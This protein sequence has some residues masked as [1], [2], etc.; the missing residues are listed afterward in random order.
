MRRQVLGRDAA[1]EMLVEP[2]RP[3]VSL[4]NPKAQGAGAARL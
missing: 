2:L 4:Q 3:R 1:A